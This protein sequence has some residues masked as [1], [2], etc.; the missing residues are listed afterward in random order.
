MIVTGVFGGLAIATAIAGGN[1]QA[2]D[3]NLDDLMATLAQVK[4]ARAN[5]TEKKYLSI[6]EQPVASS[7]VLAFRAPDHLE[8]HTVLPQPEDL[9][10]DGDKLTVT[11]QQHAVTLD[12]A[13][14]PDIA[15]LVESIRATLAGNRFALQDRFATRLE[16]DAAHW[17]LHLTPR[18]ST[19]AKS[20]AGIDLNGSGPR[21]QQV[22][23][24]QADGD[25]SVTELH[26]SAGQ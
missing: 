26:S 22:D 24:K 18:D 23:V 3:W 4:T 12:L 17:V 2:A 1:A 25:R 14:Y 21:L 11:R 9:V 13:H 5:F 16:G 10:L 20:I 19:L 6:A 15:A 7:G 8:K